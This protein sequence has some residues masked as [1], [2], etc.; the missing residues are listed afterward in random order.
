MVLQ[1][2]EFNTS[3]ERFGDLFDQDLDM[4]FGSIKGELGRTMEKASNERQPSTIIFPFFFFLDVMG[5]NGREVA[6]ANI[7]HHLPPIEGDVCEH[8]AWLISKSPGE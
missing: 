3:I 8:H 1:S 6:G 5:F 7:R 2:R 4:S